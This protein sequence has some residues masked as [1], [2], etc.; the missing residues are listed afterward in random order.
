MVGLRPLHPAED[1]AIYNLLHPE[2][3]RVELVDGPEVVIHA[4]VEAD[5]ISALET[6]Q[7]LSEAWVSLLVGIGDPAGFVPDYENPDTR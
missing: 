4:V 7:P 6:L 5:L 3:T 1:Q 2:G